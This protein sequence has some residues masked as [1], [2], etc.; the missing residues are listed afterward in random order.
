MG[1]KNQTN[2][3]CYRREFVITVIVITEFDCNKFWDFD[4]II[5]KHRLWLCDPVTV[6]LSE[7]DRQTQLEFIVIKK[8]S[9][10]NQSRNV[11]KYFFPRIWIKFVFYL[12]WSGL[13]S[14]DS[15]KKST[16]V[17][18]FGYVVRDVLPK[19]LL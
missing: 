7:R 16:A 6:R 13:Q 18:Y 5:W 8:S 12:D 15:M 11:S 4:W 2:F 14:N 3:A 9:D 17:K 1:P 19:L 10:K